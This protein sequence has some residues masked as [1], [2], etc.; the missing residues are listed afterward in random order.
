DD[1]AVDPTPMPD[2]PPPSLRRDLL[3]AYVASGARIGSWA[4][5]SAVVF[6]TQGAEPFAILALIRSTLSFLIFSTLGLAPAL[7]H[8]LGTARPKRVETIAEQEPQTTDRPVL[9]YATRPPQPGPS[10]DVVRV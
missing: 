9:A 5:V 8:R 1:D 4:V 6:R 3:S 7:V 10:R 2:A